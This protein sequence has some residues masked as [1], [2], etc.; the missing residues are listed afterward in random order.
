MARLFFKKDHN[1]TAKAEPQNFSFRSSPSSSILRYSMDVAV[2]RLGEIDVEIARI[3]SHMHSMDAVALLI[4]GKTV[5]RL[6]EEHR[7]LLRGILRSTNESPRPSNKRSQRPWDAFSSR[8]QNL[9]QSRADEDEAEPTTAAL[10]LPVRPEVGS[11]ELP[12][13]RPCFVCEKADGSVYGDLPM[14]FL[15]MRL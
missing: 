11:L 3:R 15:A 1:T 7:I 4:A 8:L 12:K 6:E 2:K 9:M 13:K 5:Q 10:A 14:Q